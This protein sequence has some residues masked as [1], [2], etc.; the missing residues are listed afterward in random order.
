M[1]LEVS[2]ATFSEADGPAGSEGRF[3][4]F[5]FCPFRL[6]LLGGLGKGLFL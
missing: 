3:P 2:K 4:F 5:L 6:W 1:H